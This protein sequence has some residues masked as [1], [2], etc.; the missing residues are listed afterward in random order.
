M[1]VSLVHI[2]IKIVLRIER[3]DGAAGSRVGLIIL[4]SRVRSPLPTLHFFQFLTGIALLLILFLVYSVTS[5][6]C[7]L[8]AEHPLSKREVAG[9]I[10]AVG[11]LFFFCCI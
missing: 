7:S 3:Q 10:P 2:Q 11:F 1:N 9:S 6:Q 8:V 4:R 5:S